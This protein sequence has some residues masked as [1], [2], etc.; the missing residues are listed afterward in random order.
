MIEITYL[1]YYLMLIV[2]LIALWFIFYKAGKILDYKT[3]IKILE[4]ENKAKDIFIKDVLW[5]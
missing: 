3:K 5:K 4:T 1:T 2:Y